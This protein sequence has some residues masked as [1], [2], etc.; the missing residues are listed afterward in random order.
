MKTNTPAGQV[1]AAQS[2]VNFTPYTGNMYIDSV[3]K[4][5]NELVIEECKHN[6][7]PEARLKEKLE[8]ARKLF[9]T[10]RA[11]INFIDFRQEIQKSFIV[12]MDAKNKAYDFI[13]QNGLLDRFSEF[14]KRPENIDHH[15]NAVSLISLL[16]N[17]VLG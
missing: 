16:A 2:S 13:L 6:S 8:A 14:C 10:E 4:A 9:P 11:A 3:I 17:P 1:P 5:C 12:E 15:K 7:Y